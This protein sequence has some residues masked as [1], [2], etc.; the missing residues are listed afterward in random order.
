MLQSEVHAL[1]SERPQE[2]SW[3]SYVVVGGT[4][5]ATLATLTF[6]ACPE[7][8]ALAGWPWCGPRGA[9][10]PPAGSRQVLVLCG[11]P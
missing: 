8:G 11:V 10:T 9:A 7:P 6:A 1:G 2:L 5:S 4:W 3:G